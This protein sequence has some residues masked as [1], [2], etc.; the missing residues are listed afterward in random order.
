VLVD[1]RGELTTANSPD[2]RRQ[3]AALL[4]AHRCVILDINQLRLQCTNT[5]QVLTS[6]MDQAGGWPQARLTVCTADRLMRQTLQ[7][8]GE[9]NLLWIAR[10]ATLALSRCSTRPRRV[11]A[12]W[13]APATTE[14]PGWLRSEVTHR[15]RQW[16]L[17]DG[18]IADTLIVMNEL[19]TNAV[20]HAGTQMRVHLAYDG[21]LMR[22]WVRDFAHDPPRLQPHDAYAARG[23]GLQMVEALAARWGWASHPNGKSVWAVLR[24]NR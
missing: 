5:L 10:D 16:G 21:T 15:C 7:A 1:V 8:C 19:A 3:L 6:A 9:A 12:G 17:D 20:D 18:S 13:T 22:C 11:R 4:T 14:A 23:R 24:P 2:V